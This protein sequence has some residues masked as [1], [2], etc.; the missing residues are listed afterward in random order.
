MKVISYD[1]LEDWAGREVGVSSWLEID[2]ERIN[3]FADATGDHQWIHVDVE[4]AMRERGG[5]IAH[6]LLTLSLVGMFSSEIF[7]YSGVEQG[8]N[9]G[10]NKIRFTN[11]V[12]VGSRIRG[13]QRLMSVAPRSGGKLCTYEY[14]I[15]IEGADRPA[16]VAE[17]LGLVFPDTP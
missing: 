8:I 9:Y 12:P 3:T 2:Q 4:R 5:T 10:F 13:R 16:C 14:V 11:E 15:E 17:G 6:G 1:Q 7:T